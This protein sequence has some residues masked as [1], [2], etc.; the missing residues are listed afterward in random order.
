MAD[1]IFFF[2]REEHQ[3]A[4]SAMGDNTKSLE[5]ELEKTRKTSYETTLALEAKVSGVISELSFLYHPA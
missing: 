2:F 3:T 4:V 1:C 5:L